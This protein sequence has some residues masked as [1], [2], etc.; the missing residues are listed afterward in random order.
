LQDLQVSF[1]GRCVLKDRDYANGLQV[2]DIVTSTWSQYYYQEDALG[3]TRLVTGN[4]A[5]TVFQ[6]DYKPYGLNF[7]PSGVETF[8]YTGKPD[9]SA[10]G[11]YYYGARFYDPSIGRFITEDS[12][13][14]S[15]DSP[16]SLNRYSYT[17]DN[18]MTF[19]DPSGNIIAIPGGGVVSYIPHPPPPAP[20]P[21]PPPVYER[22]LR[23]IV[24][25]N[26]NPPPPVS[27]QTQP[28]K[29]L[30]P[31]WVMQNHWKDV[32]ELTV[33]YILADV[34][35]LLGLAAQQIIQGIEDVNDIGQ[36]YSDA[37]ALISDIYSGHQNALPSDAEALGVDSTQFV[38]GHLSDG[39]KAGLFIF[40]GGW[41]GL[42]VISGAK[43]EEASDTFVTSLWLFDF[44]YQYVSWINQ[45]S[46]YYNSPA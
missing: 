26:T 28:Q 45:Y 38:W 30:F 27:G 42:N 36:L 1:S 22:T 10:I 33:P 21:Q 44:D 4:S 8:M 18:P 41:A 15:L 43:V 40:L 2:E 9:D 7:A 31:E 6:S 17:L 11:L 29:L 37:K 46:A 34:A 35:P 25:P 24:V 20:P 14:G 32:L 5:N 3:S 39:Q 13:T 23:S 19:N 12:Q 16:L